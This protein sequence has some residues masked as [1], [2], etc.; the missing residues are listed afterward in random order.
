MV[1]TDPA[2]ILMETI[3]RLE[4]LALQLWTRA[5]NLAPDDPA[6]DAEG[7]GDDP[8]RGAHRDAAGGRGD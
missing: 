2:L 5:G 3:E 8:C 6:P 1:H 7:D 4:P